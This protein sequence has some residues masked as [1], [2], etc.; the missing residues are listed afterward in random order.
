MKI[1][2]SKPFMEKGGWF[3]GNFEPSVFK[4]DQ[5]EV[6]YKLHHKGEEWPKHHH[7]LS[8][9]INFLM[10][11]KMTI[12]DIPIEQGNIFVI[13]KNESVKPVFLENC[14]LIVVKVPCVKNDKYED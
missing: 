10:K 12:N 5:F 11:G 3:I 4:T 14:E 13:D 8:T 9:E 6:S 2:N 7:K 1:Y